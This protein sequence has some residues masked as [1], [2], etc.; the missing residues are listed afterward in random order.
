MR[1]MCCAPTPC[2]CTQVLAFITAMAEDPFH[3]VALHACAAV[4]ALNGEQARHKH[5]RRI[6]L[7]AYGVV[8]R[9]CTRAPRWWP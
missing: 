4:V 9:P 1:P 5:K 3:E 7:G 6:P 2:T 8:A